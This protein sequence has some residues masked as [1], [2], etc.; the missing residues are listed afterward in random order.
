V[1]NNSLCNLF[2]NPHDFIL[3]AFFV[4]NFPYF[5]REP[6]V[7]LQQ[8]GSIN[9]QAIDLLL[10]IVDFGVYDLH[11][12]RVF[13]FVFY[14]DLH[15]QLPFVLVFGHLLR[16]LQ[17]V[18]LLSADFNGRGH[19]KELAILRLLDQL[20]HL[21]LVLSL[22]VAVQQQRSVVFIIIHQRL[23]VL[24]TFRRVYQLFQIL[25]QK[26]KFVHLDVLVDHVRRIQVPDRQRV[27]LHR[28]FVQLLRI[29]V[30][31]VFLRNLRNNLG[32]EFS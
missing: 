1:F 2:D 15:E 10:Q 11:G 3:G 17:S 12:L 28:L 23:R 29:K 14:F 22:H 7:L 5:I 6:V 24:T 31:S 9:L 32:R 13:L 21:L 16:L 30:V 27:L 4:V 8:F 20:S 26:R 19:I 18:L 25:N